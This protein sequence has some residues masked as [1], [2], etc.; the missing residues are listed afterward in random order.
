MKKN[1]KRIASLFL[2]VL[3]LLSMTVTPVMA[4]ERKAAPTE[5]K[6]CT[7]TG[8]M[9]EYMALEFE[10]TT[11]MNKISSVTVNE[12]NY[13]K[14]T[15]DWGNNLWEVGSVMGGYGSYTALKLTN[16]SYPAT[17]KITAEGYQDLNLEVTKDTSKYPYVY[18]ATVKKDTTGGNTEATYIAMAKKVSNGTVALDKDKDLKAGDTVTVTAIPAENYEIDAVTV[19]TENNK[20][21]DVTGSGETY[22]FTMPAE[23][24]TVSATFKEKAPA[25]N[26]AI[27]LSQVSIG[28]DYFGNNWELEFKNADGYV[29]KITDVKV[30]GTAWEE[31]S[32]NVSSGGAYKKDTDNNKLIFAAK[33]FGANSEIP[34]LKSGDVVAIS[35]NGYDDLTFKLVIDTNGN[36][37]LVEDDGKGDP[38][39]LHV[40]IEGEFEAAIVGQKDYDGVS[41]ASVGGSSSNKNSAVKVYGALVEK[42]KD[43]ADKDW[44]ELDNMAKIKL[45]GSKCSVSIVPDTEK[46]TS[47]DSDS[48]MQG[49]YMTISSDLTL[50]GTPKDSG[51]YLV[52][53]SIEDQQGRSAVSNT[54]P[55]RIYS[56][57]ETLA[58]QMKKE[59]FKDYGNGLYAWDI[60]EPWAISKFGSNVNGEEESV[61]VPAYLEA[62]FG[63][64]ESGT[65]GYLGYDIPWKQVVAGNIPQTLYIPS[66]CNLTLTNMEVLSSVHIIVENGGKLT[67]SDS[68]VQGI[69]DVQSGGTFSMNYD[70]FNNEFTTGASLCGQLRLADG[71]ALENA[72]IYSHANYLANGDLTD[73]TTSE[74]VA[75]ANGNVTVKGT[76]AILGDDG[77]SDI[78]QTAL[79]VNGTLTLADKDTTLVAYGGSG[80]TLLYTDGGTAID[81]TEGSQI[82]GDGKLVAIGGDVLWGNGGNAVSGKGTIATKNVFLQGAT[83]NTSKKAEAGKAIDG[84]VKVISSSTHIEDG[85]MISGAE[86]DP[87]ADLYWKAGINVLPPLEKFTTTDNGNNGSDNGDNGDNG[88]NGSDNGDNGDN[89]NNGSGNGNTGNNSNSGNNGNTGNSGDSGNNGKITSATKTAANVNTVKTGDTNN[90]L[91]WAALFVV[92]CAG[93]AGITVVAK[94]RK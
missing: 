33:D 42:G 21:V 37:S 18:T 12:T 45:N 56:G 34:A 62:W 78:G 16:P 39:E 58:D 47:A 48:G 69:I 30:N 28:T 89:G 63:S 15:L 82:T 29:G 68:V 31:K 65:Y 3:L 9:P 40:K 70:S 85:T 4:A 86:N 26:G 10:D 22:T 46:G 17:I 14:G 71:A 74:P 64:H 5:V 50:S 75:V 67:L 73:R 92:S 76:V 27:E 87:L 60:M 94:K 36:A 93:M 11:W 81:I 44:E 57:E 77:G 19:T 35:A 53:V 13:T 52:S 66:G 25:Q 38:Y 72:A 59:N 41:S 1:W 90:V 83:A 84:N 51:S 88:N 43:V 91:L 49:V 80:K 8:F 54:L 23:N 32:Y 24:V 61:R 20:N 55:F 2:S 79:R 7:V 6:S